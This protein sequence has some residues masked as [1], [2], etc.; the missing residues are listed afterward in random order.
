M[1]LRKYQELFLPAFCF[2][3]V[4]ILVFLCAASSPATKIFG[5]LFVSMALFACVNARY[6]RARKK[7]KEAQTELSHAL[8]TPLATIC[9]I[10][11]ILATTQDNLDERQK[12]LIGTLSAS[13]AAIKTLVVNNDKT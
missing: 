8:R 10:A 1:S 3:M 6:L 7:N 12:S 4:A 5:S 13:A 9:G 11:E 2:S